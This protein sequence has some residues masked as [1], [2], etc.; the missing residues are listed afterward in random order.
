MSILKFDKKLQFIVV[1]AGNN[2][3]SRAII[4]Y[5]TDNKEDDTT[6]YVFREDDME[7]VTVDSV[8]LLQPDVIITCY[9]P[10]LLSKEMIN[11]PKYGC[12][13][14]HPSLLPYNRG[15][16]PSVWPF[17]DGSPAGVTLHLI[18]EGVDTGPILTQKKIEIEETDTGGSIYAK[19]QNA[20]IQLFKELWSNLHNGGVELKEQDHSKATYHSK[21]EANA[22]D[23]LMP[24]HKP[25]INLLRAKTFG[26]K[27][28]AYYVKD[29][30]KYNVRI[31]ITESNE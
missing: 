30:K 21:K 19:S 4:Q 27:G 10:Y 28:Y 16:Y 14:F 7:N 20:I 22:L 25:I 26:S 29:G 12:I 17:I 8:T 1:F 31:D 13:N 11:I 23:W 24:I 18:D 5:I 2:M 3:V 9:W 6:I 15:W